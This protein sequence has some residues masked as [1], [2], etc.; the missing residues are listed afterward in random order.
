[1]P[2]AATNFLGDIP[3]LSEAEYPALLIYLD[4]VTN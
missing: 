2:G 4:A 3:W 1:M